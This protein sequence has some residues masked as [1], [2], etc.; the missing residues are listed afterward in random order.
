MP[1]GVALHDA[2]ERLLAAAERVLVREGPSALTSRAVTAEAGL[3]KGVL[4]RHFADFDAFL[5]ELVRRRIARLEP[6]SEALRGAAGSATVTANLTRALGDLMD[7]VAVAVVGLVVSRDGLRAL[8]RTTTPAGIPLLNEAAQMVGAYLAEEQR[9][10]RVAAGADTAALAPALIGAAHLLFADRHAGP[11][12]P[13]VLAQAVA[14]TLGG[15]L[16]AGDA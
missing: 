8:L 16:P 4:H 14:A 2:R 10:G 12:P 11:P 9:R 3:A 13:E 5:A 1:T 7:P 6:V 15:A